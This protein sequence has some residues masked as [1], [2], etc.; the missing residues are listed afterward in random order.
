MTSP[1]DKITRNGQV[2]TRRVWELIDH[3]SHLIGKPLVVSQGGFKNGSG[4][5]ASAGVHDAG[6]VYDIKIGNLT[7]G[8]QLRVV[9]ELRKWYGDAWLRTPEFGWPSS[10]GGPHIHCVQAD[11]YYALARGAK[12]QIV[13]YNNHKNGLKN[14][15]PDP[16][17]QPTPRLHFPATP[18]PPVT[19]PNP[20]I[21]DTT[22]RP[23]EE[24]VIR[25]LGEPGK[26]TFWLLSGGRLTNLSSKDAGTWTGVRLDVTDAATWQRMTGGYPVNR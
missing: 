25:Y 4:A 13:A 23:E 1:N 15:A 19:T 3:V 16:F 20:P 18:A 14:N 21:K 12:Q 11:S 8:E 22:T 10:A 17:P 6:D 26:T 9:N 7:R 2:L 24:M 5:S